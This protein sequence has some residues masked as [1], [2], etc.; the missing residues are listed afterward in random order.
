MSYIERQSN[1]ELLR[2]LSMLMVVGLHCNFVSLGR[3]TESSLS[4]HFGGES[5]RIIIENICL[6]SVN[7]F[8]LISGFFG[9]RLRKEKV[10]RYVFQIV[11]IAT[12]V[13]IIA[14]LF[15]GEQ[16]TM[17]GGLKFYYSYLSFNWFVGGYFALMLL[18]PMVNTFV[19]NSNVKQIGIMVFLFFIVDCVLGYFL[20][21]V[22]GI[23]SLNGYSIIHLLFIYILGR[24]LYLQRKQFDKYSS[25]V[26]IAVFVVY[27]L[28]NSIL[29]FLFFTGRVCWWYPIAYNNPFVVM[30]SVA[31]FLV[32]L[33][34]QVG[35][36]R[37]VNTLASSAFAVFLIHANTLIYPH[38]VRLNIIMY[39]KYSGVI[40]FS[41]F[42]GMAI[43]IYMFAFLINQIQIK[44]S[45]V[46]L[47]RLC[48][49]RL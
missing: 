8:V 13:M 40:L 39:D 9:I 34:L 26:F 28:I 18:S 5:M 48:H 10:F 49:E 47:S 37:I 1:I 21:Y 33:K 20:P 17:K 46:L 35:Y 42:V 15:I 32:F 41:M 7:A 2:I 43:F 14:V 45:S 4:T 30:G 27:V 11:F 19:D 22:K 23:G 36:N 29:S 31:L 24:L 38:F 25:S 6:V 16:I 3:P 44:C 12:I